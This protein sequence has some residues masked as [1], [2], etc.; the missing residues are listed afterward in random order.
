MDAILSFKEE[1][2]Y[3]IVRTVEA[4]TGEEGNLFEKAKEFQSKI[5]RQEMRKKKK[6]RKAKSSIPGSESR[7]ST[8]LEWDDKQQM[9]AVEF[10]IR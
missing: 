1:D 6:K 4:K 10:Y 3:N 5:V 7:L 8:P 2:I 9:N